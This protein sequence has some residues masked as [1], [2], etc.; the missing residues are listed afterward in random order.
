M[1]RCIRSESTTTRVYGLSLSEPCLCYSAQFIKYHAFHG[2]VYPYQQLC[3]LSPR[4]LMTQVNFSAWP[5]IR[6]H[7]S[8]SSSLSGFLYLH[9]Q[10]YR[11]NS[12][13]VWDIAF[14]GEGLFSLRS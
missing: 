12:N 5:E 7:L 3:F 2:L 13:K 8:V 4:D 10:N 11:G 1:L 9:L 14:L 6:T